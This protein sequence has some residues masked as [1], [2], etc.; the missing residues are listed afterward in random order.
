[1]NQTVGLEDACG[2][3]GYLFL[4]MILLYDKKCVSSLVLKY[5]RA[6]NEQK[7]DGEGSSV[8]Y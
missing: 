1:M 8:D 5:G 7:R 3:G 2:G 4:E 6:I